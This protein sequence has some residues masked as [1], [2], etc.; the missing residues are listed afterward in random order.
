MEAMTSR[1][2]LFP[3]TAQVDDRGHLLI[4]SCDTVEL[5]TGYGTP[6]YVF[7]EHTMRRKC[8]E[9][10]AEF[11]QRYGD[12][13][14]IY[15]C[16][17]LINK[18]LLL[19]LQEEGLGLDVVS[20]G[21]LGFAKSVGFPPETVYLHGNNKSTEELGLA[22][23]WHVG[24][25]VVDNFHELNTLAEMVESRGQVADILIR[26]TPGVDPHTHKYITTGII[27]SKFGFS[28]FSWEDAVA[29]A[30][31]SPNLNLVG[32]HFHIG[33]LIFE[34]E[35]Y[36]KSVEV[37]LDFAARMKSKYGFELKELNVGGGFAIQ[38]VVDS[39]APPVAYY[40]EAITSRIISK[41]RELKLPLPGLVIEPG[42]SIVG[43][44]GV[45]LY[46]VGVVKDIPDVRCYASV[47]GGMG[48]NIRPAL[49][50]AVYEAVIANKMLEKEANKVTIAGKF[51]ESGDVLVKDIDLPPVSTG[52]V[53]AIPSCGAYC[54][55]M[56]SNYNAAP[57]PAAVLV[58]EGKAR[59]IRRHETLEDLTACDII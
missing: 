59:L 3:I 58:K 31:S 14:V 18:A 55:S 19:I 46:Q 29:Q 39:P 32:L 53:I 45:A 1:L 50:D 27:D 15:A 49:Y 24:R 56:A 9:Y 2:S 5:A 16:K 17:A 35:P 21:E 23:D 22:L 47:D 57:K 38:Y 48:D 44:A 12:T 20:G 28:M 54:L 8:A 25:I 37:V 40:A 36:E 33:S 41:C 26:L 7:D 34:S 30:M 52:D 10:K 4:G 42:R 6:L 13:T 11:G 51:C 43:K